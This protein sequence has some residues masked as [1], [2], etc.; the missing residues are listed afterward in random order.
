MKKIIASLFI[1]TLVLSSN[2]CSSDVS[3]I[4]TN[5]QNNLVTAQSS[6]LKDSVYP[7]EVKKD[8]LPLYNQTQW[9][10]D[11]F[12]KDNK[13]ITSVTKSLDVSNENSLELDSKD[14]YYVVA[15]KKTYS[16]P[17]IA[18]DSEPFEFIRRRDNQLAYGRL[19]DITY[20]PE[21]GR[22]TRSYDPHQFRPY[23]NF[24]NKLE[25]ITVKAGT[26][27][28]VK[29]EFTL[30]L[31][32]YT[33][34]YAQGIGEVKRI[35][36]GYFSSFRYELS[37]YDSISK[38]FVLNKEIIAL[39]DVSTSIINKANEFKNQYLQLNKLP[40]NLFD[41]KSS[42]S[43]ISDIRIIR[44]NYKKVYEI[45]YVTKNDKDNVSLLVSL[46]N[47][48]S[49]TNLSVSSD[50]NGKPIYQGKIVDKLPTLEKK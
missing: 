38:V 44:D 2:S 25:S 18:K 45:T 27:Q 6:N 17:D 40:A 26:F 42:S 13:F 29:S 9:T 41:I 39:K 15:L 5:N 32:K 23:A 4:N 33:I 1:T 28:C 30:K 7:F 31:D 36:E 35:K 49:V 50:N 22:S 43:S 34:W 24:T 48:N 10:Y 8:F 37:K 12:D 11:I 47:S 16:N 19:D 21:G 14:N 20:Y 46:D 3:Q